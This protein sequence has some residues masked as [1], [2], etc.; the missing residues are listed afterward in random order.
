MTA[1]NT[2]RQEKSETELRDNLAAWRTVLANERTLLAYVRTA[3]SFLAAGAFFV[4]FV[5]SP[6]GLVGWA[7]MPAGM[8]ILGIGL[9]RFRK[10][11]HALK[12]KGQ[13]M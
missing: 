5:E 4:K 7:L 11:H 13:W 9:Y 10:T 6:L 3:L 12:S 8:A 1:K 2:N